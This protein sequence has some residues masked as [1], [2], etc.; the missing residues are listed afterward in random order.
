MSGGEL[1]GGNFSG[2]N[3]PGANYSGDNYPITQAFYFDGVGFA[4]KSNSHSEARSTDTMA[5]R[6]SNEELSRSAKGK[7]E[8]SGGNMANVFVAISYDKGVVLCKHYPWTITGERFASFVKCCF[9]P[10]FVKCGNEPQG[11]LFLQ[12][13]DP[14]KT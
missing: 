1:S 2:G 6:K 8:G 14:P 7:K 3:C 5:W 9:P 10:T 11:S 12:G 4:H 13:V